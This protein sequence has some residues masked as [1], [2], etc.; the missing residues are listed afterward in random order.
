MRMD[1]LLLFVSL[2]LMLIQQ[3]V[4][5]NEQLPHISSKF[6]I[7]TSIILQY[8]TE[9]H[10]RRELIGK[11]HNNV[12]YFCQT[13][14]YQLNTEN[15]A[16]IFTINLSNKSQSFF[17]LT[18]PII[19]N[20]SYG[21]ISTFWISGLAFSDNHLVVFAQDKIIF[22][23]KEKEEEYHYQKTIYLYNVQNGYFNGKYLYAFQNYNREGFELVRY[24]TLKYKKQKVKV[25]L[26]EAPFLLQF[27][28]NRYLSIE[29]DAFYILETNRP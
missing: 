3:G 26:M 15:K 6:S 8:Y 29:D 10:S 24:D 1:R 27:T 17:D 21:H 22:Y 18:L 23:Q 5:Q 13:K 28:P 16:R 7:D 19:K 2:T 14:A 4:A 11:V 20:P 9:E 25:F 12:F